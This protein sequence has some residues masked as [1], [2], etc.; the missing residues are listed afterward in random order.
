MDKRLV[1]EI[2]AYRGPATALALATIIEAK[3]S[4]P[5]K[6]GARMLVYPDGR[7]SGTIGGGSTEAEVV[8]EARELIFKGGSKKINFKMT[9]SEAAEEGSVCGGQVEVFL[10]T[11]KI[12]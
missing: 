9:N 11:I 12:K 7:I 1:D 4:S 6:V 5:R 2:L 3:G 10:E 8:E